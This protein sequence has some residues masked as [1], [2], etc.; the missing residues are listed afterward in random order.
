MRSTIICV[1]DEKMLI[2]ILSEQLS[3]WFGSNYRI[4]KAMSGQE[5]LLILDECVKKGQDVSVII[6]DYVMPSMKGDELLKYVTQIDPRIRKIMLTGYSSV[7]GI[8][9][10]INNGGLYR[11]ISKPWDTKDLMLTVL[12]A[13]RSYENDRRILSVVQKFD[14]LTEEFKGLSKINENTYLNAIKTLVSVLEARVPDKAG[15]ARAVSQYAKIIG[16]ARKMTEQELDFIEKVALL[17]NVGLIGLS[18]DVINKWNNTII[19]SNKAEID[20]KQKMAEVILSNLEGAS[21]ILNILKYQH[22]RYDGV[23]S[24]YGYSHDELPLESRIVSVSSFFMLK[25]RE[26]IRNQK[27]TIDS[28]VSELSLVKGTYLDPDLIDILIKTLKGTPIE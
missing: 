6:T 9:S 1:D 7:D 16:K 19:M 10:A 28:F 5:V 4:E 24:S 17:N 25:K 23:A 20:K 18:D 22:E 14:A 26:L 12:E 15:H 3:K 11:Y 8:V 2:N 13:I 21:E 27:F